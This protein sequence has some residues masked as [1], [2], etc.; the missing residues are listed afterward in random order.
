MKSKALLVATGLLALATALLWLVSRFPVR[1]AS[2]PREDARGFSPSEV[3]SAARTP[4]V[5]TPGRIPVTGNQCRVIV[6]NLQGTPLLGASIHEVAAERR[7][8][9]RA[10]A[11]IVG[12]TDAHGCLDLPSSPLPAMIHVGCAGHVPTT[13]SIPSDASEVRVIL[14]RASRIEVRCALR[15]GRPIDGV[16]LCFSADRIDLADSRPAGKSLPGGNPATAVY[17]MVSDSSGRAVLEEIP[18]GRASASTYHDASVLVEGWP[19]GGLQIQEG[20]NSFDLQFDPVYGALVAPTDHA[21]TT[22]EMS[23]PAGLWIPPR[24]AAALNL[25]RDRL[26]TETRAPICVLACPVFDRK[27]GYSPLPATTQLSLLLVG[28]GWVEVPVAL[29]AASTLTTADP[30][31]I[32]PP[33]SRPSSCNINVSLTWSGNRCEAGEIAL[34][35]IDGGKRHVV[36]IPIVIGGPVNVPVG[37]YSIVSRSPFVRLALGDSAL[38]S[39]DVPGDHVISVA[40]QQALVPIILK[41]KDDSGRLATAG[42][43]NLTSQGITESKAFAYGMSE[44]VFWVP[45]GQ[46]GIDVA[47]SRCERFTQTVDI[48]VDRVGAEVTTIDVTLARTHPR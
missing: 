39:A 14:R 15:D 40:L 36:D 19:Q 32:V 25:R 31:H 46:L 26:Q 41:V 44:H 13:R 48:P 24:A 11:S 6:S 43:V 27:D 23:L 20:T 37:R 18:P 4:G 45:V 12:M 47:A 1:V 30:V 22:W 8:Y 17:S 33:T 42:A 29:R 21:V 28:Q 16:R 7:F 35:P 34:R 2:V 38:V 10:D 9:D 5:E 3:E